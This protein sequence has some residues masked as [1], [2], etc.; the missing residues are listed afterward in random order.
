[1][2]KLISILATLATCAAAHGAEPVL[3]AAAYGQVSFG[4]RIEAVEERLGEQA[5]PITDTDE[6]QCRQIEF[7]A[8]PGVHFMVERGRVTRAASSRAIRTSIGLTVGASMSNV[9][10]ALPAA[11]VQAHPYVEGGHYLILKSP[12]GKTALLMEEAQDTVTA[13]RGG[14][15]PSVQY[16]EGCL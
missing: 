14:L 16:V 5:P 13:V 15:L 4:D 9:R 3:S 7:K 6:E 8:Y 2:N 10:R 1:M 12:D 11:A